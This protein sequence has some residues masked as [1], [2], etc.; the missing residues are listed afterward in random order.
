MAPRVTATL[1]SSSTTSSLALS[2]ILDRSPDWQGDAEGGPTPLTAADADRAAMVLDDAVRDP[3]AQASPLLVLGREERLENVSLDLLR[4]TFAG[5]ADHDVHRLA[6][7]KILVGAVRY[8]GGHGNIAALGHGLLGV[9]QDVE[10]D[11]LD[12]VGRGDHR[13]ETWVEVVLEVN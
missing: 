13:R 11:L 4:H 12:L 10:Q 6:Q 2:V 5:V 9:E 8:A 1:S 7:Q 3:Q